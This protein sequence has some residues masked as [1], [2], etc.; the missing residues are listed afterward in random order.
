MVGTENRPGESVEEHRLKRIIAAQSE[1]ARASLGTDDV[2]KLIAQCAAALTG[3][4]AAVVETIEGSGIVFR[5]ATGSA[6]AHVGSRL[7]VARS[8]AGLCVRTG[9]VLLCTDAEKDPRVDLEAARRMGA[10]SIIAVP[11]IHQQRTVGVLGI[12]SE[13][14][15]AF[16]DAETTLLELMANVISGALDRAAAESSL[17]EAE[18]T[19]RLTLDNAPI[20]MAL[21]G[22]D[23]RWLRV[24]HALCELLGYPAEELLTMTFQDV[25][26]PDDLPQ[27][28]GLMDELVR[29]AIRRVQV[30]KKYVRK[31][32]SVLEALLHVSVLR[33]ENGEAR[34]FISQI[35]DVGEKR[36][37]QERLIVSDRLASLGTLA[38]GVAHEINNPLAFAMASLELASEELNGFAAAVPPGRLLEFRGLLGD[39]REG[40]ERVRR[41]VR[42]LKTFSRPEDP[43]RHPLD[44]REVIELAIKMTYNE[45]KHRARLVKDFGDCPFVEADEARLGQVFVN[46][47][48]N[49]AQAIREGSVDHNEI[50]IR[51]ATRADGAALIE[52][53]DT[54]SGIARA[55]VGK[56]FDPFYT[57]KRVGEGTGLGLSI[58][59]SIVTD[60]GGTI[61]V[62]SEPDRGSTFRVSLPAARP[63]AAEAPQHPPLA[64]DIP[65]RQTRVLIVDDEPFIG[66]TFAHALREHTVTIVD[67]ARAALAQL[68]GGAPFDVVLCDLM[69]PGMTGMELYDELARTDPP[70][71]QRMVFV[72]G[73][74]F[75]PA[76]RAFLDRVPNQ[77]LEK[78]VDVQQLRAVVR[79]FGAPRTAP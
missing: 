42:D 20:G 40:C 6:A 53:R 54:G 73:G 22:L 26:H 46:L 1:I 41:I 16:G 61:E 9:Q 58:C 75:T 63:P 32:G 34:C 60:L 45:V 74:A 48:V 51:T 25:T 55:A 56:I 59:R 27:D 28:V 71:S 67:N 43:Q 5:A 78:P 62:E 21:V 70:L 49:A 8:M 36:M 30:A 35:E 39:A 24:N 4:S 72:T 10:R 77:R 65:V 76:A 15:D 19:V 37:L 14:T 44:V 69:M 47:L 13:R 3:A 12:M 18:E 31:D 29:G 79:S 38:A 50:R 52:V 66:R 2:M 33:N 68:R 23:G 11:L 64:A 57:T 7:D 17:R